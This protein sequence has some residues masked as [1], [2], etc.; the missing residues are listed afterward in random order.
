MYSSHDRTT[1][2]ILMTE[3]TFACDKSTSAGRSHLLPTSTFTASGQP[4]DRHTYVCHIITIHTYIHM[5]V[6]SPPYIHTHVCH[7]ITIHTYI[8][9]CVTSSPYIHTYTCVS[10]HHHTY[11][12]THV[13]HIITIHTYICVSHHHHTYIHTHVCHII[14]IHTYTCVS[15]HQSDSPPHRIPPHIGFPLTSDSP[16]RDR[17]T[18]IP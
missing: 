1:C 18:T 11:I 14:T 8:H 7:I 5:C 9:M 6:T 15:H 4:L 10:H 3:L 16:S 17:L 13:C 12:H 2:T